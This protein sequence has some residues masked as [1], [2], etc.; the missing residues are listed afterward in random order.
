MVRD[1]GYGGARTI[2][3]VDPVTGK[4]TRLARL[5]WPVGAITVLDDGSVIA[6]TGGEL[7]QIKPDGA[8]RRIPLHVATWKP[9][10]VSLPGGRFA[11][12]GGLTLA[13]P[14][15]TRRALLPASGPFTEP[16]HHRPMA[17]SGDGGILATLEERSPPYARFLARVSDEGRVTRLTAPTTPRADFFG[18]GDGLSLAQVGWATEAEPSSPA[19]WVTPNIDPGAMAV[20][21]DG[22]LLFGDAG[23]GLRA[24]VPAASRRPRIALAQSGYT[25]FARGRVRYLAP[26]QGMATV[27]VLRGNAV[28]AQAHA[29]HTTGGE[30]EIALPQALPPGRY[31]LRLRLTT[32]TGKAEAPAHVD[33]R[34]VLPRAEAFPA[35]NGLTFGDVSDLGGYG[36][37]IDGCR[38]QAALVIRCAIRAFVE[39]LEWPRPG[40]WSLISAPWGQGAATLRLDGIRAVSEQF[41]RYPSLPERLLVSAPRRQHIGRPA[42]LRLRVRTRH[43][44]RV[45]IIARLS[46]THRRRSHRSSRTRSRMLPAGRRWRAAIRIPA[47]AVA[48]ARTGHNVRARLIVRLSYDTRREPHRG[49]HT[50]ERGLRLRLVG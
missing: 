25:S 37:M 15:G 26:T 27:T 38:R 30:G 14:S 8:I 1:V 2:E 22:S 35:V 41:G 21:V 3:R 13:D 17:A 9:D 20:A 31:D 19:P 7:R 43:A 23:N 49:P 10:L 6:A 34:P 32:A 11:F 36:T 29:P 4:A 18:N 12:R 48:A 50:E 5:R 24:I 42:R 33:T 40:E 46:W 28:V 45:R 47:G 39:A 44:A 16:F